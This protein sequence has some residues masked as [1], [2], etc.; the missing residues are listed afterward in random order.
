MPE[1]PRIKPWKI[2]AKREHS[3]YWR[4]RNAEKGTKFLIAWNDPLPEYTRSLTKASYK[5][6]TEPNTRCRMQQRWGNCHWGSWEEDF[7]RGS[8]NMFMS[9][10]K[11]DRGASP[12]EICNHQGSF[13]ESWIQDTSVFFFPRERHKRGKVFGISNLG[14]SGSPQGRVLKFEWPG[15]STGWDFGIWVAGIRRERWSG[16]QGWGKR[17]LVDSGERGF[18]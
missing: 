11:K 14:I 2:A 6:L 17:I 5:T 12:S 18:R 15:I 4:S 9:P 13:K 10:R 16:F 7:S 1:I 8:E 3:S